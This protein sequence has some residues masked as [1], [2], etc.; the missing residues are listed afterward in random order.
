[1]DFFTGLRGVGEHSWDVNLWLKNAFD[2]RVI[3]RVFNS[4]DTNPALLATSP[5]GG[6]EMVTTN[7][8]RQVGLTGTY[9]F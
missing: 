7:P 4:T 1:V 2:R 8:P 5:T 9:R 3:T 6:F